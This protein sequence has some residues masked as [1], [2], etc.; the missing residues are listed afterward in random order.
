LKIELETGRLLLRE[1]VEEDWKS[2]HAYSSDPEVVRFMVWGPNTED[3]TI[4]FI[5]KVIDWQ[6]TQPRNVF[7][8]AVLT[9]QNGRLIGTCGFHITKSVSEGS[10]QSIG[11]G[12][13]CDYNVDPYSQTRGKHAALGYCFSKEVWG[14]GYATEAASAVVRFGFE[15]LNLHKIFAICDVEN[16][17]SARVLEKIGMRKEGHLLEDIKI[18]GQ[19]RDSLLFSML[20]TE[21]NQFE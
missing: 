11:L 4:G 3:E 21:C 10:S 19:W 6:S 16:K 8:L 12:T 18:K 14:G 5:K 9:K 7:D 15:Q 17:G 13:V 20:S 2:A 1:F